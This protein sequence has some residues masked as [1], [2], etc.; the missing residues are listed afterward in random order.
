MLSFSRLFSR[1]APASA[2]PVF[3]KH[4][5]QFSEAVPHAQLRKLPLKLQRRANWPQSGEHRARALGSGLEFDELQ[6]YA[7]GEDT[8][9]IDWNVTA[10]TGTVYTRRYLEER[11]ISLLVVLDGSPSLHFGHPQSVW[12]QAARQTWL[13]AQHARLHGNRMGLLRFDHHLRAVIRPGR[14]H[15]HWQAVL[16]ALQPLQPPEPPNQ[17]DLKTALE[18]AASL[19]VRPSVVVVVSDFLAYGYLDTLGELAARHELRLLHLAPDPNWFSDLKG[20]APLRGSESGQ[21]GWNVRGPWGG[22]SIQ[23]TYQEVEA[24]L[25]EWVD[26]H[27][28]LLLT[29][30][31]RLPELDLL[32]QVLAPQRL[33][34]QSFSPHT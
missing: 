5:D 16:Q 11:E 30:S 3:S 7:W 25:T 20:I 33:G 8:R 21:P 6:P 17:S 10:R 2:S 1:K 9:Y 22:E 4:P 27:Q 26:A 31:P 23:K 12:S 15:R 32:R 28:A 13:L 34:P 29:A 19:L 18:R 24:R 14:G